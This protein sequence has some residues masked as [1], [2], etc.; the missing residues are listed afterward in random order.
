MDLLLDN[1]VYINVQV[2]TKREEIRGG[3]SFV[4][5]R[6]EKFFEEKSDD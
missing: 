1:L 3:H 4:L 2:N 6:D 5:S